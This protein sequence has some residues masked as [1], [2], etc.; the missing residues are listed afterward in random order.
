MDIYD[1]PLLQFNQITERIFLGTNLCCNAMP[2]IKA[3]RP[4]IHLED[5]QLKALE[6]YYEKVNE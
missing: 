6:K 5:I 4:E 1:H 2:H 3:A